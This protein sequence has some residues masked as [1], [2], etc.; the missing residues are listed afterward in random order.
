MADYSMSRRI[1]IGGG[2]LLLQSKISEASATSLARSGERT[3]QQT[4]S[5]TRW[6]AQVTSGSLARL[7]ATPETI[8]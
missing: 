7:A 1:L 2:A 5:L 8:I 4:C 3:F 6:Q